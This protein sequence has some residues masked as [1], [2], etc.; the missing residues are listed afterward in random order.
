MAVDENEDA[1]R[2]Q[3]MMSPVVIGGVGGSGTRIVAEIVRR[4]GVF[5]GI[6][7]ALNRQ[8]DN[9]WFSLLFKRPAWFFRQTDAREIHSALRIFA[10]SMVGKPLDSPDELCFIAE[11]AYE[12]TRF[13]PGFGD[14]LVHVDR[15][16]RASEAEL[17]KH[18]GW[19]WKE[20]N[21]HI[22]LDHLSDHFSQLKYIHTIRHGMD[23]VY[24]R[25]QQQARNWGSLLGLSAPDQQTDYP[26][27]SLEF[28]LRANRRAL[29]I[30][31]SRLGPRFLLLRFEDLVE[32]PWKG[33]ERILRFLTIDVAATELGR[34]VQLVQTPASIG[35]YRQHGLAAFS[36]RQI[37]ETEQMGYRVEDSASGVS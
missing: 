28:W 11:A 1:E 19:G 29:E 26:A 21:S 25:N 9:L 14:W 13:E 37:E 12:Y 27:H 31:E 34:L 16:L 15:F 32:Q 20:P 2:G 7:R 3:R 17:S 4:A 5:I 33:I 8:L 10:N 35:R 22:Y 30:G 23:M 18:L 36:S 24:S 6:D